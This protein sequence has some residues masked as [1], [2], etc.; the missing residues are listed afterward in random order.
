MSGGEQRY[1]PF[2]SPLPPLY[3]SAL[4]P[5]QSGFFQFHGYRPYPSGARGITK[6]TSAPLRP[7][8]ACGT[9]LWNI[10]IG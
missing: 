9:T 1:T 5:Y 4:L 10:N 8:P 2:A 7:D 3:P 6:G